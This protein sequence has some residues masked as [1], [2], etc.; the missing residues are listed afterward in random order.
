MANTQTEHGILGFM[1]PFGIGV[2]L[3]IAAAYYFFS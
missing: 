1:I 2:V 3:C